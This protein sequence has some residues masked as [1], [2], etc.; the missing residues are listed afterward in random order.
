MKIKL[1][2]S[3]I[4]ENSVV[5]MRK[6]MNETI[7]RLIK[8]AYGRD[9]WRYQFKQNIKKKYNKE[10][11]YHQLLNFEN[12]TGGISQDLLCCLFLEIK[13]H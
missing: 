4:E 10:I 12:N 11:N 3:S 9:V 2:I 5:E 1:T 7:I 8:E 6:N 13:D